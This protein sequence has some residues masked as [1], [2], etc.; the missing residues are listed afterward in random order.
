M[1]REASG[2]QS[3]PSPRYDTVFRD[4]IEGLDRL[5]GEDVPELSGDLTIAEDVWESDARREP[6]AP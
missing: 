6:D 5:A 3:T 4:G 2:Q 1:N